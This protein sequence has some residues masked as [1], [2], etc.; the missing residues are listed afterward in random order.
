M[1]V[2][3]LPGN[4]NVSLQI[5]G[6]P[7]KLVRN[8]KLSI[9]D[10]SIY[11]ILLDKPIKGVNGKGILVNNLLSIENLVGA[12][13]IKLKNNK[14]NIFV[15]GNIDMTKF[16]EPY[17]DL[18]AKGNN[19]FFKTLLGDIE[20]IVNVDVRL[21]GRD[22]ITIAGGIEAIDAVIYQEFEINTLPTTVLDPSS[23]IIN[24]KLNF[25]ITGK[26]ELRN[27]QIDAQLGGEL[28]ISKFGEQSA[29][30]SGELFV[31]EGKFYYYGDIF[32]I[33]DGY[34]AFDT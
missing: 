34:L 13:T 8:G 12:A 32:S 33:T 29:D 18:N 6:T 5:A 9:K 28:S 2:D 16:F 3:S 22:T 27:S 30:Y 19:V 26:F 23:T 24:Y 21:T 4:H 14:A 17:F 20:G 25:P 11:T 1:D 15:D 7:D 31:R 10:G